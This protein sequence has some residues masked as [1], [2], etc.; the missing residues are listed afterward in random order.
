[1]TFHDIYLTFHDMTLIRGTSLHG[2]APLAVE[3][4]LDPASLLATVH[5]D[6]DSTEDPDRFI[7]YRSVVAALELA[8]AQSG[9]GDFARRLS[10]RQGLE[11]LGPVGIAART[12]D[13]VGAA[14]LSVEHYISVYSPAL[15]V[16]V[17]P[18]PNQRYARFDWRIKADRPPPHAQAAELGVGVAHRI[19]TMFAGPD[20]RP[21]LVNFRHQPATPV[22]DY[23]DDFGCPVHF[24][25]DY[26]GFLFTRAFL[27]RPLASDSAV[28]QVVRDYLDDLMGSTPPDL[29]EQVQLLIRRT[30]TTGTTSLDLVSAELAVHPRSLQRQLAARGQSFA[31]MLDNVRRTEAERYLRETDLPMAGLAR[32]LGYS[33]QS[34]LARSCRRWFGQ[35][36]SRVRSGSR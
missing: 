15:S 9:R 33:E 5:L 24:G 16:T 8:A 30:L 22:A 13:T 4:G 27:R 28:H 29:V 1:L 25:A 19:F 18:Q 26:A 21:V 36:P 23:V 6:V 2:F 12:A 10:Q 14:L 7:D 35:P 31:T 20:F 34:V 3:C 11:I 32:T 17:D